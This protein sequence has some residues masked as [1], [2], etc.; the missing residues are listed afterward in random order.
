[1]SDFGHVVPDS[2]KNT[3]VFHELPAEYR[4]LLSLPD[5][6]GAKQLATVGSVDLEQL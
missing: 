2:T 5:L 1:M 6:N 3:Q 4:V